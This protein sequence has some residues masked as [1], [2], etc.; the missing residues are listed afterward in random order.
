MGRVEDLSRAVEKAKP[1]GTGNEEEEKKEELRE[2]I[3][4]RNGNMVD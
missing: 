1:Q 2:K 3:Y 4:R